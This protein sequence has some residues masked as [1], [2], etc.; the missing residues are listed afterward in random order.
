MIVVALI[1]IGFL[2]ALATMLHN[3]VT[4]RRLDRRDVERDRR[5][6]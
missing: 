3:T 5:A 1:L 4:E 6:I 2:L